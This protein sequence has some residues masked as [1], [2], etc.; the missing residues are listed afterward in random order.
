MLLN[1]YSKMYLLQLKIQIN[2]IYFS[3]ALVP[4]KKKKKS[5]LVQFHN[6][7]ADLKLIKMRSNLWAKKPIRKL[8]E[9]SRSFRTSRAPTM[10]LRKLG[11]RPG[12]FVYL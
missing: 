4:K 1:Y 12:Q 5:G 8:S 6:P 7:K 2:I 10:S 3:K 11:P 9:A